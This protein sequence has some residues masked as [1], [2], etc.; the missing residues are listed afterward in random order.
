M[1][2]IKLMTIVAATAML[3]VSC[4]Q[5]KETPKDESPKYLVLYY[6]QTSNTKAV[7][8]QIANLLN[9]DIEEIVAT[10]P[11][12][13]D[14]QATIERCIQERELGVK[15]EIQPLTADI[16]QY[17]VI[18]I[19]YPV[20]FGTYAPPVAALLDQIDLSGKKVVPFCTFGS[21]GLES[22]V[23][24]LVAKQPNAEVLPGYGVRAARLDAMPKEVEEFL[25]ASGLLEGE[26]TPLPDF[27][28]MHDVSADEAAIFNTAV[29]GYPMLNAQAKSVAVRTSPNG[30]E[31]LFVAMDKP[32]ESKADMS[33]AGELQVYVTVVEG[34]T[35]VFTKVIR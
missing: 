24:D 32:R 20:W 5:K 22:S 6:S 30:T 2:H 12:D 25:K 27:G 7:A 26:Y 14:F 10:Q 19:G 16:S 21:G 17:D 1:K 35:P 9:A 23:K 8:E 29:D 28:E 11:Y 13:G 18:F 3:A 34:E 33:P 4:G 15:P 31:Y